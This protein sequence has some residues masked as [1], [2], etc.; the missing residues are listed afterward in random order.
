MT[1]HCVFCVHVTVIM[2]DLEEEIT[3][4]HNHSQWIA[5]IQLIIQLGVII[6]LR[7]IDCIFGPILYN[8]RLLYS[9]ICHLKKQ[10]KSGE[11]Q[12]QIV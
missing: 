5:M 4:D 2:H 6:Q 8:I 10:I 12:C 9:D 1:W 3:H 7:V 11:Y